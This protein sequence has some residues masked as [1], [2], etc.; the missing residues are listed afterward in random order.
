MFPSMN[1]TMWDQPSVQRN[2]AQLR[3]DGHMVVP[4]PLVEAWTMSSGMF[5]WHPGIPSPDRAAEIVSEW[6][7]LIRA[8]ELKG[9]GDRRC[10][11]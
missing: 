7:R 4:P 1:E 10:T 9:A 2:V 3:Q 8:N 6:F 5:E 11:S